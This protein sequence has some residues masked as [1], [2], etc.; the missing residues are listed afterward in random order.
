MKKLATVFTMVVLMMMSSLIVQA[1]E[2]ETSQE[3]V[4]V[5]KMING[6]EEAKKPAGKAYPNEYYIYESYVVEVDNREKFILELKAAVEEYNGCHEEIEVYV[7]ITIDGYILVDFASENLYYIENTP[8]EIGKAVYVRE[9][10][11][12]YW[13][14]SEGFGSGKRGTIGT[15]ES[16]IVKGVSYLDEDGNI[17]SNSFNE[18][19]KIRVKELRM[20]HIYSIEGDDLGWIWPLSLVDPT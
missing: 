10:E 19:E 11:W 8:T 13:E 16:V 5:Q 20:L 14:K 4:Q 6:L 12:T 1:K 17:I 3:K 2:A 18:S 7:E 9:G 15:A